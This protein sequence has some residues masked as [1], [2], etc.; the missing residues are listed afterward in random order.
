MGKGCRHRIFGTRHDKKRYG[1]GGLQ[2][3]MYKADL[4][5]TGRMHAGRLCGLK[6]REHNSAAQFESHSLF[7]AGVTFGCDYCCPAK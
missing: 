1:P 4:Y 7:A 2:N 3:E 6:R 5:I